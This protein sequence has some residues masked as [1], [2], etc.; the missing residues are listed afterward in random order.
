V[1]D[2]GVAYGWANSNPSIHQNE[3]STAQNALI[4]GSYR[5]NFLIFSGQVAYSF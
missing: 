4:D 3:G 1:F 5:V 2:V